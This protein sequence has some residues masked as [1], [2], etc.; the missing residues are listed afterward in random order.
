MNIV[1]D[2]HLKGTLAKAKRASKKEQIVSITFD[3]ENFFHP[4]VGELIQKLNID[5]L[6]GMLA[7]DFLE[8]LRSPDP[9]LN[10]DPPANATDTFFHYFGYE[11]SNPNDDVANVQGHP[12]EIDLNVGG[13]YANYN[14]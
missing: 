1:S 12:K 13:P 5:S 14:W 8:K 2:A 10:P 6:E 9:K 4:F 11:Y 7:S 3:F